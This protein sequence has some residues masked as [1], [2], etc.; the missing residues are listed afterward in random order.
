LYFIIYT[1][2]ICLFQLTTFNVI[3]IGTG[4]QKES[5]MVQ[6]SSTNVTLLILNLQKRE[7]ITI[8]VVS[9]QDFTEVCE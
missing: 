7:S 3:H 9:N 1:K 6:S 8:D 4:V 2:K 5:Y